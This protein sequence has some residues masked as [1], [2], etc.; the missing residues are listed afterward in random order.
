MAE[1]IKGKKYEC[2][3][4]VN[5][6]Y[7]KGKIYTSEQDGCITDNNENQSHFWDDSIEDEFGESYD[8]QFSSTFKEVE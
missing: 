3:Q 4:D 1:P 7:T 2:I 8:F 5:D 6:L